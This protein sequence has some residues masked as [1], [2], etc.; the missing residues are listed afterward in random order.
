MRGEV[1]ATRVGAHDPEQPAHLAQGLPAGGL[2]REQG[3]GGSRRVVGEHAPRGARLDHHHAHAVRHDI[4]EIAGDA[5]AFFGD[6]NPRLFFALA[7][8]AGSAFGEEPEHD[9]PRPD[10]T[11]DEAEGRAPNPEWEDLA[12]EM[13]ALKRDLPMNGIAD[14]HDGGKQQPGSQGDAAA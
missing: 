11:P 8:Q 3:G 10:A 12:D 14:G 6:S 7:L 2:D 1:E 5:R 9:V 4:V 13:A